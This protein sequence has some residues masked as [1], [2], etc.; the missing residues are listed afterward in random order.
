MIV[1][2]FYKYVK[3][4]RPNQ[5]RTEHQEFCTYLGIRGKILVAKEGINGSVSGTPHQIS[6]YKKQLRLNPYFENIKF[7]DTSSSSHP[8]KKMIVRLRPEI[9]TFGQTIKASAAKHVS[10]RTL[11]KWITRNEAI[12]LDARNNYETKIGKFK[13]AITLD[14]EN[15][16]DFSD[17][18]ND[19]AHFKNKKV[20]MYCTGGVR[21]EK[22][23]AFLVQN[24]FSNV[25][26]LDGGVLNY[27]NQFPDTHFEGRCFVFDSRLSVPTGKKN[28][29]IS[30]C[31]VCHIPEDSYINC[32]NVKCDKLFISCK[33]CKQQFN[34]TCSKKCRS[35]IS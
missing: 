18:T 29:K 1:T 17:V 22:S 10:P 26:Q 25:Y 23:S 2:S 15:F 12:L 7:K 14:I 33:T 21:C 30:K 31:D 19:I 34:G 13:D 28:S 11:K 16:R 27:I 9:V 20:V 35:I 24:G 4:V 5:F 8:F 32:K 6:K 3:I